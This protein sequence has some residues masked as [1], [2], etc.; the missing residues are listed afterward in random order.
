MFL[1][2]TTLLLG[3]SIV[4][5]RWGRDRLSSGTE[6]LNEH[7]R[8]AINIKD[9][10]FLELFSMNHYPPL[11]TTR[12]LPILIGEDWLQGLMSGHL[13]WRAMK[14]PCPTLRLVFLVA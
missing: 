14:R 13:P 5:Q 10:I 7:L 6:S 9:V 1:G 12:S 2:D 8:L 11:V 3:D 4:L